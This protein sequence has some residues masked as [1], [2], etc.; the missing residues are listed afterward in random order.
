MIFKRVITL[1]GDKVK[2]RGIFVGTII[3]I[4]VQ[5]ITPKSIGG[6]IA[7]YWYLRRR[8]VPRASLM[9]AIVVNSFI[10]QL[11]NIISTAIFVPIGIKTFS[12]FFV[13]S[14][15]NSITFIVMLV[16]GLIFDTGWTTLLLV[17]TLNKKLQRF[18]LKT[19][20]AIIEI[21][22]FIRAYDSFAIKAKFEYELFNINK[23]I[24]KTFKNPYYLFELVLL[25]F[26]PSLLTFNAF[27]AQALGIIK[28]DVPHGYYWNLTIQNT[29]IRV[30][31]S[32]SFTPGGTGTADYLYKVLIRESIRST[33]YD[34]AIAFANSS[35]MTALNTLG[36]VVIGTL[37]SAIIL[38]LVYIGEKRIDHYRKK[39]KNYKLLAANLADGRIKTQS[40]YYKIV[41]PIVL[42][43][44]VSLSLTF[45]L[46]N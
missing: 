23:C 4:V 7:T 38:V 44:L 25:K 2:W 29:M 8:N 35:I 1:Q 16:L 43:A 18:A 32:I 41:F 39:N 34:G 14:N 12:S 22:P 13:G 46:V 17:I 26:V 31:N 20:I 30:A 19:L 27:Q 33:S 24:K 15:P 11:G 6:D 3:G 9:S 37:V 28:P 10:W 21:T 36:F 5:T 42:I 40:T 45:I